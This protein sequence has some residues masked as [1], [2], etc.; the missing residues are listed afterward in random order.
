MGS[1]AAPGDALTMTYHMNRL[2]S[3]RSEA[4]VSVSLNPPDG[5]IRDEAVLLERPWSHPL[6]TFRTLQSQEALRSLQGHRA[7]WY[8]GA[9]LGYGFHE[10]GCRAGYEAAE[11]ILATLASSG[12]G[13]RAEEERAA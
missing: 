10:D 1:C 7:T 5:R 11:S 3:L 8:A 4:Q 6:Y 13:D 9:H 12:D 2:Q